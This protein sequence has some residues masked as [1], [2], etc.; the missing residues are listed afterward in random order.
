M[1]MVVK[2]MILMKIEIKLMM[3]KMMIMMMMM[4]T[5]YLKMGKQRRRGRGAE[6]GICHQCRP[7]DNHDD[8]EDNFSNYH[9]DDYEAIIHYPAGARKR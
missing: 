8:D 7:A 2:N 5:I 9:D 6:V 1:V 4:K 3:M